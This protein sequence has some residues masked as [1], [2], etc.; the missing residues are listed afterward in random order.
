[1]KVTS[2]IAILALLGI[3]EGT[4][5]VKSLLEKASDEEDATYVDT[6]S[7]HKHKKN[8]HHHKPHDAKLIESEPR[9]TNEARP[10]DEVRKSFDQTGQD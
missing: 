9:V 6:S 8:H 4:E 2:M 3:A 1:M 5:T 10:L 7:K